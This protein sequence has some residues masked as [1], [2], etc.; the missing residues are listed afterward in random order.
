MERGEEGGLRRV[1][2]RF[3]ASHLHDTIKGGGGSWEWWRWG[4]DEGAVAPMRGSVTV[5]PKPGKWTL[6][7]FPAVFL[8][9]GG[10]ASY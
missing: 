1:S 6:A 8:G 9:G 7:A 3:H 5:V 4:V 2:L 10:G